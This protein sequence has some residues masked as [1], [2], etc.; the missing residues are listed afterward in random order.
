ML[1]VFGAGC[2]GLR[3]VPGAAWRQHHRRNDSSTRILGEAGAAY[4]GGDSNCSAR[5]FAIQCGEPHWNYRIASADQLACCRVRHR[6][7]DD[8]E[9]R[10]GDALSAFVAAANLRGLDADIVVGD[11]LT[12]RHR[13]QSTNLQ[14]S[15]TSQRS[16]PPLSTSKAEPWPPTVR[17]S[18]MRSDTQPTTWT[19]S[20]GG[21]SDG[22]A[23]RTATRVSARHQ[24]E[25]RQNTRSQYP[26]VARD[27]GRRR[28]S[29]MPRRTLGVTA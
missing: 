19:N 18:A 15:S 22:S 5:W 20:Q 14:L 9:I 29:V 1:A 17:A 27:A 4:Q 25:G 12:F 3:R 7:Y 26:A 10:S 8:L 28:D 21:E 11:P 2:D 6:T 23:C 24:P 13:K 16:F